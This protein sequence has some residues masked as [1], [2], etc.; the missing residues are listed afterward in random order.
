MQEKQGEEI[1]HIKAS[2][3]DVQAASA[4]GSQ[5]PVHEAASA[6][7]SHIKRRGWGCFVSR[8]C[9]VVEAVYDV[10]EADR[11]AG[12]KWLQKKVRT[13]K[14]TPRVHG[15]QAIFMEAGGSGA[16]NSLSAV[17]L[18]RLRSV[19]PVVALRQLLQTVGVLR[20]R[21]PRG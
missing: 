10:Y 9:F 11:P 15:V 13:R 19:L 16:R 2:I 3:S 4:A 5:G 12:S 18:Q 17:Q 1:Q 14:E 21:L 20:T 6:A 7:G 8:G